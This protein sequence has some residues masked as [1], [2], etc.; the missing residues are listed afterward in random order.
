MLDIF[1]TVWGGFANHPIFTL[2]SVLSIYILGFILFF[3]SV[4]LWDVFM[5]TKEHI[6][7]IIFSAFFTMYS[8]VVKIYIVIVI[9]SGLVALFT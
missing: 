1:Y 8:S 2:L 4:I 7:I 6:I 3:I 5:L 9:I